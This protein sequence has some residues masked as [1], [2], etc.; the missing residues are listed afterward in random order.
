MP[1][2]FCLIGVP[3]PIAVGTNLLEIVFSGGL[4]SLLY[5]LDR[6]VDLSIVVPL[7][8]GSAFG[9]RIGSAAINIVDERKSRS[10]PG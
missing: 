3:M 5:A 8:T 6:R 4:E 2:L 9:A 7:L 1:A 10:T